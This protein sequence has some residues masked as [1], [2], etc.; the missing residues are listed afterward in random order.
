MVAVIFRASYS[1]ETLLLLFVADK[2]QKK[3]QSIKIVIFYYVTI[4]CV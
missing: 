3:W 4:Y 2:G 1:R